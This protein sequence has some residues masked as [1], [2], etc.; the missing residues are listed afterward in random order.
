MRSCSGSRQ[1]TRCSACRSPE[2]TPIGGF[3]P[4][5]LVLTGV[6]V[7]VAVA[8]AALM[9]RD[10]SGAGDSRGPSAPP[11]AST[12]AHR[13]HRAHRVSPYVAAAQ[14][15]SLDQ[16]AGQ[17]IIYAYSGLRP[18]SS[19]LD[20]IGTG[21]AA[22]VIFFQN[23]ISSVGQIRGVIGRLQNAR[24]SSP[25]L[26]SAA[27]DDR[28]G[29]RRGTASAGRARVVGEADRRGRPAGRSGAQRGHRRRAEP[30][31]G[32]DAGQP[33]A[34]TRR[35]QD[36][37]R[38]R[39]RVPSLVLQRPLRRSA[40]SGPRSS[41]PS[42]EGGVLATAKHFPGLGATASDQN[43]D[44]GPVTVDTSLTSLRNVDETP[45]RSAIAAGVKLVM[46]SWAVYPALDPR[47]PAGLSRTVIE[48][49]LRGRLGFRGVTITDS[50]AAGALRSYGSLP[51]RADGRAGRRRPA[52]GQRQ[53][54]RRG[55]R[56]PTGAHEGTASR[57]AQ[58][59]IGA[60]LSGA[61]ARA[62]G[63]QIG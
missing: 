46:S 21:K 60:C 2:E 45:Y 9:L 30:R 15:M 59:G 5:A 39:R 40:G 42:S 38:L 54:A 61:R 35:I 18:P 14:R 26:C 23:N 29:G 25:V 8:A 31:R 49:E 50:L 33:G 24:K 51:R 4:R 13:A 1:T 16:L 27:D 36:A 17:R 55:D 57:T 37:G 12:A 56:G 41:P 58:P 34:G 52:A 7:A 32:A 63:A 6:L 19:L 11:A 47:R 20:A 44:E 43:T 22:G 53:H 28:P 10:G 62:A 48:T 3:R